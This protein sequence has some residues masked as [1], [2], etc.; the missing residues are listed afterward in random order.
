MPKVL[1]VDDE[2]QI[3]ETLE[4]Y[5]TSCDLE[6]LTAETGWVALR[7][8]KDEKNIEYLITCVDMSPDSIDGITMI[9]LIKDETMDCYRINNPD[10]KI[11]VY[12]GN[13]GHLPKLTNLLDRNI[14]QAYAFKPISLKKI[15]DWILKN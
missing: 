12:T 11:L 6:V 3:C 2:E 9:N 15:F 10:L 4:E 8:L 5:F 13:Q 14:I 1:V 7:V